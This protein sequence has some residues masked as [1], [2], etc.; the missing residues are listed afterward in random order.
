MI[1]KPVHKIL[2]FIMCLQPTNRI[3]AMDREA[4][5]R[6]EKI[7]QLLHKIQQLESSL[8]T[9]RSRIEKMEL[10]PDQFKKAIELNKSKY[11]TIIEE[12]QTTII[13]LIQLYHEK[14]EQEWLEQSVINNIN[15]EIGL[16]NKK[17]QS[18]THFPTP[19]ATLPEPQPIT[20]QTTP[21]QP[22][23]QPIQ[24]PQQ[25]I[26]AQPTGESRS[27]FTYAGAAVGSLALL[28]A[29]AATGAFILYTKV[30]HKP[31]KKIS[32]KQ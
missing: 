5:Q 26:I 28:L 21:A 14:K 8:T 2:I 13:S 1:N 12:Y 6:K 17:L 3:N 16:L 15:T 22:I 18:A 20:R 29:A 30:F 11:G 32:I 31:H 19:Q 4:Q 9:L 10:T 25:P 24:A 27:S 23:P 7:N